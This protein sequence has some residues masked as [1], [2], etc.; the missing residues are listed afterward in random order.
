MT[1]V[2]PL[3]LQ[4]SKEFVESVARI[5]QITLVSHSVTVVALLYVHRIKTQTQLGDLNLPAGSE[6]GVFVTSLILANKYLD[7]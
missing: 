5:L 2:N 3:Q 4:P 7:E 1:P 6:W